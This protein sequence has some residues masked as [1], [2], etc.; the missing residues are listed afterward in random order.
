[1]PRRRTLVQAGLLAPWLAAAGRAAAQPLERPR[2]VYGFA[3]GS[4]GDVCVRRIAER[5]AGSAYA[6]AAPLV[7]NRPGGEGRAAMDLVR[8]APADGRVLVFTPYACSAVYPHVYPRLGYDPA[9]DFTPVS[10]AAVMHHG[11]AVGPQVPADVVDLRGFLAWARAQPDPVRYGSPGA[12]S[13]PHLLGALLGLGA[14]LAL[15]HLPGD[16][17]PAALAGLAS[18]A[19]AAL[20]A[21][22]GELLAA[23][24]AGRL[25]LLATTGRARLPFA[26]E[27]PTFAEQGWGGLTTEEWFGFFAPARTPAA[28]V[29]AA[30]AAVN[31]ALKD[32]A[33]V[34][35]LAAVGLLAR[36]ST[37]EAMAHSQR[38]ELARW[39]ML[40]RRVGYTAEG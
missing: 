29:Q 12:G 22:A 24:R 10:L 28:V 38:T 21:P 3:A 32:R 30:N 40:A 4:A 19:L 34:D 15:R 37:I 18:G 23:H 27:L 9:R 11:L 5:L 2:L 39:G 7:E 13:T 1:M 36:G 20:V 31:Q 33:V 6:R 35:A 25:R 8:G 16:G 14:G 26:A 17:L